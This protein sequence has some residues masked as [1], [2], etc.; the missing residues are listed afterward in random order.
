MANAVAQ[1]VL[2]LSPRRHTAGQVDP[3]R[4]SDVD[5]VVTASVNVPFRT[6]IDADTLARAILDD[7][8]PKGFSGHLARFVGELPTELILRFCDRHAIGTHALARFIRNHRCDLAIRR[9]DLEAYI[10]ELVPAP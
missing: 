4:R 3:R 5:H 9:P 6:I 10:D 1:Q 2:A 8:V 7:V